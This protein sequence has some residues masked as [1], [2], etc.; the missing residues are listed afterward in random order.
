M[1]LV[2]LIQN[3]IGV[4]KELTLHDKIN[5][6]NYLRLKQMNKLYSLSAKAIRE[7][8]VKNKGQVRGHLRFLKNKE[9]Q[10]ARIYHVA[11]CFLK[12]KKYS[13]VEPNVEN[14]NKIGAQQIK[15]LLG[16]NVNRTY[17]ANLDSDIAKFLGE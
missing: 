6:V 2:N 17:Y 15:S 9:G 4:N 1:G 11:L 16:Y 8:A 10:T 14:K 7:A 3:L 5:K 13:E 12:G